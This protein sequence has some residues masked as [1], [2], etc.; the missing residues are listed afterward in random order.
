MRTLGMG[1]DDPW[2]DTASDNGG[3]EARSQAEMAA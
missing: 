1:E 2:L 3:V